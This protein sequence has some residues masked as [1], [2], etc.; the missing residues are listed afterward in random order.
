MKLNK[1][2]ETLP[3]RVVLYGP[4][5]VGKST[6]AAA[7][8]APVF[9]DTEGGTSHMD[10]TRFD[11]PAS[12]QSVTEAVKQL[13]SEDH[14]FKTLVV[15]TMDWAERLL[16]DYICRSQHKTGLEDF[17]YGKGYVY[18]AEAVSKF[19][20]TLDALRMTRG[21][22]V[23]LVAHSTIKKFEQ[24]D[25]AGAFDRYELKLTK[26]VSPLVKEWSDLLLFLNYKTIVTGDEGGKKRAVGGQERLLHTEHHAAYDAKNRHGLKA[27]LPADFKSIAHLFGDAPK[28]AG[29]VE[30]GTG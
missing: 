15:D 24:P 5:G 9:L 18:L 11:K 17:G 30:K 3:Q 2:K 20:T 26:Q 1:G 21:M 28:K 10:V 6:L 29:K 8:P 12:W 4:E 14:D 16:A 7:F 27:K 19:L 23:L 13:Q 22:N 25:T